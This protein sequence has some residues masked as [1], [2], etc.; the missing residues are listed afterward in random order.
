MPRQLLLKLL[1]TIAVFGALSCSGTVQESELKIGVIAYTSGKAQT[2]CGEATEH[3]VEMMRARLAEEPL[4]L[5]GQRYKVTLVVAGI[6]NVPEEAVAAA[7]KLINQDGVMAIIGP[8]HSGDAIQVGE[9]AEKAGIVMISP[10]STNPRTTSGKKYV[11]RMGFLDDLQ[12]R[13]LASLAYGDLRARTAAV[14]YDIA[15]PYSKNITSEFERSFMAL[16]GKVVARESYVTGEEKFTDQARRINLAAPDIVLLPNHNNDVMLQGP[17]L[18]DA[19]V[20]S[21]LLGTDS[22]NEQILAGMDAFEGSYKTAHWSRTIEDPANRDFVRAYRESFD[23]NPNNT[24]AM[25]WDAFSILLAALKEAGRPEAAAVRDQF[26]KM[27]PYE[28]ITGQLD[29]VENGDPKKGAVILRLSGGQDV[30]YSL[31]AR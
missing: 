7:K 10:M 13:A 28:G 20:S 19:G 18:K 25:T 5:G 22:W 2:C 23:E 3:V 9:V 16:G 14:L 15:K 12:G 1:V 26:Y 24:A 30:F 29:F 8:D 4:V 11:F 31:G 17:I 27:G 21:R 6:R